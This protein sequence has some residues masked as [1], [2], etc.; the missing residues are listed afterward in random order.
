MKLIAALA[1]ALVAASAIPTKTIAERAT[2]ICGQWDTVQTGTY[3]LY[4]DLWGID[5]ATSGSQCSTFESL[6]GDTIAWSTSWSWQ[7]GNYNVKS[8]ANVVV[9]Q[10]TGYQVSAIKSIPSK[11]DYTYTGT[12]MVA[13][14]AYDIFSSSTAGGNSDGSSDYEIMI[15]LAAIGGAGPISATGSVIDTPTIAGKQW[16]LYY[17]LN[18]NMKVYSFVAPSQVNSFSGDLKEF[19]TYLVASQGYSASQYITSIG[20][21][22]EPFIGTDAVMKTSGYSVVVNV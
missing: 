1:P 21:G 4:Q 9:T 3:T 15:W 11:W 19:Y 20:A 17:G 16:N 13:D 8:F 10:S 14:V 2:E 7:G 22:T 18:G 12:G 5:A 6:S